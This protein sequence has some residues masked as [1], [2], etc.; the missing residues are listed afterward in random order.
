[1]LLG[2]GGFVDNVSDSYSHVFL[3]QQK[4]ARV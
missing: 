4:T 2:S 3:C 1:M